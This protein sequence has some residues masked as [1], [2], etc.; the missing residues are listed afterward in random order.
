MKV[1]EVFLRDA[2]AGVAHV[3]PRHT[4]LP[5]QGWQIALPAVHQL[6]ELLGGVIAEADLHLPLGVN[7]KAVFPD[8]V[9]LICRKAGRLQRGGVA[10]KGR[11]IHILK[12]SLIVAAARGIDPCR[13]GA[14]PGHLRAA[15]RD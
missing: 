6:E 11:G 7:A 15:V 14:V 5:R 8:G 2:G 9:G 12:G 1:R 3:D 10:L 4:L 13:L